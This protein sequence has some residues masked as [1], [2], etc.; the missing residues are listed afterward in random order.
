MPIIAYLNFNG[1]AKEALAVY[2]DVFQ[3]Q[4]AKIMTYQDMPGA[5]QLPDFMKSMVL[6][7]EMNLRGSK[8]YAADTPNDGT[9][10][11]LIGNQ[12]TLSIQTQSFD[13]ANEIYTKLS[14]GGT[15][16]TPLGPTFFSP[17]YAEFSDRFRIRWMIITD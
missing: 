8:I 16:H 11:Y 17:A 6:H 9:H 14:E 7:A 15:I 3:T 4:P 13:E 1:N 2:A 5:D 12:V 10:P